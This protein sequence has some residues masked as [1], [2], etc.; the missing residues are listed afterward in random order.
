MELPLGAIQHT[1]IEGAIQGQPISVFT[2]QQ[3]ISDTATMGENV[4]LIGDAVGNSHWSVG[5]GMQIGAV[6]HAERLKTL[7]FDIE[8]GMAKQQALR[9]YSYGVLKDTQAWG[10]IGIADFYPHL[11]KTLVR[12][13]YRKSVE[14]W[15]LYEQKF[16]FSFEE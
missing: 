2:L 6:S 1:E 9:K 13:S 3:K 16:E 10:E 4:I 11:E 8:M 5:G 14:T 12:Q 7:L 15:D